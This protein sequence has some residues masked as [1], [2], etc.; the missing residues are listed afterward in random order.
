[1]EMHV[2]PQN[3]VFGLLYILGYEVLEVQEDGSTGDLV[4]ASHT[5]FCRRVRA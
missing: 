5:F 1:M 3:V 2:L 4:M